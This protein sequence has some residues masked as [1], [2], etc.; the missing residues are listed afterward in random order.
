[1]LISSIEREQEVNFIAIL[2]GV[3]IVSF[4]SCQ[5]L[6]GIWMRGPGH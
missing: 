5:V 6:L 4:P 2:A 1:M 3:I